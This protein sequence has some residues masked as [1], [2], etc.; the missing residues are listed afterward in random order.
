MPAPA[1]WLYRACLRLYPAEFREEYGREL[2]LVLDDRLRDS[3]S[4][5]ER[6]V[7]CLHAIAALPFA[8]AAEHGRVL[9]RD[10]RYA[11]RLVR[12]EPAMTAAAVFVSALGIG[13]ITLIFALANGLLLRPLPYPSADRL[14][15]V[16]EYSPVDASEHG[17]IALANAMDVR[18]RSRLLEDVGIY[19]PGDAT[20]LAADGAEQVPAAVVTDGAMRALGVQPVLGRL[21]TS[22]ETRPNGPRVAIISDDLF[23]RRFGGD[24]ATIGKP[25]DT[26]NASYTIVGVM[27]ASFHFPAL[28]EAWFP[29]QSDPAATPRTD[30]FLS[31]VARMKPG[32]SVEQADAEMQALMHQIHAEHPPDNGWVGRV[33][34]LRAVFSA[35]YRAGIF[36]L[37]AAAVLLLAIACGNVA[38]LLLLR[39]SVRRG[40]I[41]VRTAL[42]ASRRRLLRQLITEGLLLG[43]AGG[44]LGILLAVVGTPAVVAL[45]PIDL[46]RWLD[47]SIDA[48]VL[49]FTIAVSLA[50]SLAFAVLP[51]LA[52]IGSA[53]GDALKDAGRGAAP[54]RGQRRLRNAVVIAELAVSM[55]LLAGASL[56]S[57]S[58]LA[59]RLQPLGY[60]TASVLS[61]NIGRSVRR[62]PDGAASRALLDRIKDAVAALPG[63][64][65]VAFTSGV[66]LG[67]SHWG[68]L[69]TIEGRPRPLEQ[70]TFVNHVVVTPDYFRTVGVPL[71]QG[72]A[73]IDADY[74]A[75]TLVI[76]RGF[77][78]RNFPA[79]D[80]LGKRIR[81]GPPQNK[82]PWYTIVGIVDDARHDVLKGDDRDT[83]YLPYSDDLVPGAM[84]VRTAAKPELMVRS[85]LSSVHAVDRD[86]A[87]SHVRTLEQLVD[88]NAWR[89]RLIAVLFVG[90]AAIAMLLAAAG[91]YAV[92]SYAISLQTH[93][94]GV[95]MALGAS[96]YGVRATV[97]RQ[98]TALALVGLGIGVPIAALL[99]WLWRGELYRISPADPVTFVVAP[100][101]F[102]FVGAAA[103]YLPARRATR[104]NPIVA[105]RHD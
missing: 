85:I 56:A 43:A 23:R 50:T 24:P 12:R 10:L 54:A 36:A 61:M 25:L 18:A 68:R 66:P 97:V 58:F 92:L 6:L 76:S 27:P 16:D 98:A 1:V 19:D 70:M 31:A 93:E 78:E 75:T 47:F 71:R 67:D 42:G 89:D 30:Y 79:G 99:A 83:L 37:M 33:R 82:E 8:A 59:V 44:A 40:E 69:Y 14:V 4:A 80:A 20:L 86:I 49:A 103:A 94:I 13:T 32:V 105:L 21:F 46:P 55:T 104:V 62:Y 102:L 22:A 57:R 73:F 60:D 88:R 65:S 101:A 15:A 81:F 48:R 2:T 90:F 91:L 3:S 26:L 84:L 17:D 64:Q 77:A 96:A 9:A 100:L 35:D 52:S 38:N 29:L 53:M 63:T 28:A 87:V 34:P 39:A 7:S 95:R 11:L 72:R 51:A 5:L 41:A 45:V 74:G